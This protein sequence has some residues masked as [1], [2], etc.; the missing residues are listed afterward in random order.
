MISVFHFSLFTSHFFTFLNIYSKMSPLLFE[1]R[2]SI[3]CCI[4]P[5]FK[6]SIRFFPFLSFSVSLSL[7][8]FHLSVGQTQGEW[9]TFEKVENN[10]QTMSSHAA[11]KL[12]CVT[13]FDMLF[14]VKG[15]ISLVDEI[16]LMPTI[17]AFLS[18]K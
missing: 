3:L 12:G 2:F 4:S 9:Q 11:L 16:Q 18:Q 13:N 14:L 10:R 1:G 17:T 8:F 15:F 7:S 5:F 6:S